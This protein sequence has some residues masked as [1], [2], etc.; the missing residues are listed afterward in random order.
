MTVPMDRRIAVPGGQVFVRDWS[1][2]RREPPIILLHDSLGCVDLWRD[3]PAD[4][5]KATG[6]RV[7]AYDRLGFGRSDPHP[8]TLALDFIAAEGRDALAAVLDGLGLDT[9]I[10]CG[11]SVGGGMALS[12]APLFPSRCRGVVTMAAQTFVESVTVAGIHTARATLGP[13]SERVERLRKYH[14]DKTEWVIAAW[15]ESWLHPD[16]AG[17]SLEPVLPQV[18]CPVLA[19]HGDKDEYGSLRHPEMIRAFAGAAVEVAILTDCGHV[20][21]REQPA[22]VM[23]LIGTFLERGV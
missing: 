15:I 14:G 22:R 20:P 10:L 4:L 18:T 23:D 11:H 19:I 1:S 9:F 2:D 3:F 6:R 8:G 17:W 16:F 7:I 13:G 12:A 21:Y 5:A